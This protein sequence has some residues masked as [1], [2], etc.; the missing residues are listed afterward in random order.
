MSKSSVLACT[1]LLLLG[2]LLLWS[3]ERVA[4]PAAVAALAA[5]SPGALPSPQLIRPARFEEVWREYPQLDGER[6]ADGR[7]YVRVGL[8]DFAQL[9]SGDV[10][11]VPVASSGREVRAVVSRVRDDGKVRVISGT[12][13]AAGDAR[14]HFEL[15]VESQL[16]ELEG[17][18]VVAGARYLLSSRH[19]LGW[20][21]ALA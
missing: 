3:A 16:G 8:A 17:E 9:A 14:G 11:G 12:L 2:A 5:T 4:R 19:G 10:F 6:L 15:R 7:A 13:V 21:R 1:G 18:L 20:I